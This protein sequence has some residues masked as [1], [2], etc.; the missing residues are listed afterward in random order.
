MGVKDRSITQLRVLLAT[1]SPL[2]TAG[3]WGR[4][5]VC[6]CTLTYPLIRFIIWGNQVD[7]CFRDARASVSIKKR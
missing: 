4:Q 1:L 5:N 7:V 6:I 2:S 3:S